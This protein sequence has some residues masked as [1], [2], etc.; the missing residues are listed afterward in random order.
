MAEKIVHVQQDLQGQAVQVESPE[1]V[2]ARKRAEREDEKRRMDEEDRVKDLEVE[3]V[4]ARGREEEA[5]RTLEEFVKAHM[6]G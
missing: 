3:L 5:K 1:E 6:Q 4:C 2:E